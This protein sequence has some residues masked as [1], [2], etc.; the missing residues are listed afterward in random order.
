MRRELTDQVAGSSSSTYDY[1]EDLD[2]AMARATMDFSWGLGDNSLQAQPDQEVNDGIHVVVGT[3]R[4]HNSVRDKMLFINFCVNVVTGSS[5]QD[6]GT[7]YRQ[8]LRGIP[9]KG[10]KRATSCIPQMCWR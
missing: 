10:G 6:L 8:L 9:A 3:G 2:T 7:P 4:N 5:S 1:E